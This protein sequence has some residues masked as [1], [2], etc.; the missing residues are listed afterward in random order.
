MALVPVYLP[1][2]LISGKGTKQDAT[3]Q[4]TMAIKV[5]ASAFEISS[6]KNF[7]IIN[8]LTCLYGIDLNLK[9]PFN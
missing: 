3:I 4:Q 8:G 5:I 9:V 6:C 1:N 2:E 7:F